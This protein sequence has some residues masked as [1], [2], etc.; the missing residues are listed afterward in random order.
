[1]NLLKSQQSL[2]SNVLIWCPALEIWTLSELFDREADPMYQMTLV[3]I[4]LYK[5]KKRH[6]LAHYPSKNMILS[7]SQYSFK[8]TSIHH[9]YRFDKEVSNDRA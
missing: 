3:D 1:M 2:E 6:K 5:Q 9:A 4:I 8:N 7:L